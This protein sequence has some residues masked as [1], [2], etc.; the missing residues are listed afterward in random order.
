MRDEE[1]FLDPEA[2]PLYRKGKE[3]FDLVYQISELIPEDNE[4]LQ[5]IKENM[6]SDATQL[7]VKVAGACGGDLYDIRMEA[8]TIIRK[9]ARD[10]MITNHSLEM[11]DFKEVE[12]F[13]MVRNLIEEYRILFIQWVAS[14]DQWNYI[15]DRW[16]LFNPPGISPHDKDPDDDLP[17]DGLDED[18]D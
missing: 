13:Q 7:T 11:F 2:I 5:S 12:Y 3:I 18:D 10:L 15:I 14:F 4:P 16:G 1:E 8:A 9:A 17:F 6:I